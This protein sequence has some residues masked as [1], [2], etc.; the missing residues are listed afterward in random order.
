MFYSSDYGHADSADDP[1]PDRLQCAQTGKGGHFWEWSINE[2]D[3][4]G[5]WTLREAKQPDGS[6]P[7]A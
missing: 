3:A 2:S 7:S 4:N 5:C 6:P 1:R